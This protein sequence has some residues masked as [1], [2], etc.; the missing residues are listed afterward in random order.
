M[1]QHASDLD[2]EHDGHHQGDGHPSVLFYNIIAISL[3]V[4]T[5]LEVGVLYPP[6]NEFSLYFKVLLLIVLS[7]GKFAIVVAFFMH[8][9]FDAPLL[10]FLFAIG[11]VIGTGTVAILINVMPAPEHP[12]QPRGKPAHVEAEPPGAPPAEH[13]LLLERWRVS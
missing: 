6:L 2:F 10:T 1:S 4:V 11:M 9:F 7:V 12:L 3:F 13:S 5:A 8:L